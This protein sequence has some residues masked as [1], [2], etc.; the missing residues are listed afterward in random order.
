METFDRIIPEEGNTEPSATTAISPSQRERH[1]VRSDNAPYVIVVHT[2]T[3]AAPALATT[4]DRRPKRDALRP[5]SPFRPFDAMRANWRMAHQALRR[6]GTMRVAYICLAASL[7]AMLWRQDAVL[8]GVAGGL[9]LSGMLLVRTGAYREYLAAIEDIHGAPSLGAVVRYN[10][11][12][13]FKRIRS[14]WRRR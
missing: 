14:L 7:A 13:A 12:Y 8:I 10:A 1:D 6:A 4:G 9:V 2:V 3:S 11:E 5:W